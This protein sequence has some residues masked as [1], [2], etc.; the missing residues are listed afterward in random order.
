MVPS[1]E[2][3]EGCRRF[4]GGGAAALRGAEGACDAG[5]RARSPWGL[6][7]T[8]DVRRGFVHAGRPDNINVWHGVTGDKALRA[9]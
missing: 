1:G 4:G 2:M 6:A 8:A 5:V 9:K 7:G 3:C